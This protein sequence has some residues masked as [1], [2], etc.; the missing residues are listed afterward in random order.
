MVQMYDAGL[1]EVCD[2]VGVHPVGYANPPDVYYRRGDFDPARVFDDHRSFFFR[3]VMED[4]YDP[5]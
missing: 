4:T 2:A 3:N 1:G 5:P